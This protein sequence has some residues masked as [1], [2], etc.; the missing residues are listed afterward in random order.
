M[1]NNCSICFLQYSND[2]QIPKILKCGH[3]FC[4]EC[5]TK[6]FNKNNGKINCPTCRKECLDKPENLTTVFSL[7]QPE[8]LESISESV[9]ISES[10][11][12]L[13]YK[14][15]LVG[16]SETGKTSIIKRFVDDKYDENVIITV[17]FDIKFKTIKLKNHIINLTITDS[18]GTEKYFAISQNYLRE[19]DG[20][21][22]VFAVNDLN[23][24]NSI[25]YWIEVCKNVID[26][27][28]VLCLLGNKTDKKKE[29]SFEEAK[30][31]A[32]MNNMAYY[33][34]SAL[35]GDNIKIAFYDIA[36]KIYQRKKR[37]KNNNSISL[38]LSSQ[39]ASLAQKLNNRRIKKKR[40]CC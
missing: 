26:K 33:E 8:D 31:F 7:I 30:L 14:I 18:A 39:G 35:N 17:G 36:K 13:N 5:L 1:S 29:I 34:T 11:S 16:N 27:N 38:S 22:L 4:I 28:K 3:T 12:E 6:I 24:F 20:I 9:D 25:P 32:D 40:E 2:K 10:F 37:N 23:S 19:L 15:G 21:F